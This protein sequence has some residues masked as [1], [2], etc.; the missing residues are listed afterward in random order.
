MEGKISESLDGITAIFLDLD[1][2]IYLGDGLIDGAL[3]FLGRLEERG[4]R[5]YFLSNNSSK[6]VDQYLDKLNRL[7][8]PAAFDEVLLSTHDLLAWLSEKEIREVFLV[9]TAAMRSMLTAGGFI[10]DSPTPEYVVLGYDTEITYQKLAEAA[11]FLQQGIPLVASHP[12]TVCPT[13]QGGPARAP[14]HVRRPHTAFH[15]GRETRVS[16]RFFDRV[17][18]RARVNPAN[19]PLFFSSILIIPAHPPSRSRVAVVVAELLHAEQTR[20]S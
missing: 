14:A 19:S 3:E 10:T 12:D 16:C 5:R 13:P 4:I 18:S 15:T 8:I 9:G 17:A 20:L 7:G 1:G 2:T 11:C 6:S